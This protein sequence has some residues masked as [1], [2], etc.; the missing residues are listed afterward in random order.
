MVK[1]LG[2]IEVTMNHVLL[3]CLGTLVCALG[4]IRRP[5]N[6]Y[7]YLEPRF[8]VPGLIWLMSF[9]QV[10]YYWI[11][12]APSVKTIKYD[13]FVARHGNEALM[14]LILC[15]LGFWLGYILPLGSR[16]GRW[17]LP[18]N[19]GLYVRDGVWRVFGWSLAAFILLILILIMGPGI[20][21]SSWTAP[22]RIASFEHMLKI[23][24]FI[25]ISI[26]ACCIGLS[27]PLKVLDKPFSVLIG[28]AALFVI[29]IPLMSNFSRG[30]GLPVAFAAVAYAVRHRRFSVVG[31]GLAA[32]WV[33]VSGHA[34]LMGRG[35]HGH[36]A[37]LT[38][39]L[40]FLLSHSLFAGRELLSVLF[41][42]GDTWIVM[43]TVM[44]SVHEQ[45][46][47][48]ALS[49]LGW[50]VFQI[51]VPRI[52]GLHPE[53]TVEMTR[54]VGG[55]GSWGYTTSIFGD[56]FL[57]YSWFGVWCFIPLGVAYRMV[58]FVGFRISDY[59]AYAL[60]PF[61]VYVATSYFALMLGVFNNY[62]SWMVGFTYPLY[63]IVFGLFLLKAM[64]PRAAA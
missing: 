1:V 36:F 61:I 12:G 34:G 37:G 9:G 19:Y 21:S 40:G 16:I 64:Q 46:D 60:N 7:G 28:L 6:R 10:F 41:S 49:P 11:G 24:I 55:R 62:R 31:M 18:L 2:L 42:A 23:V 43:S 13:Q 56:A 17:F 35:V 22:G 59:H 3:A 14:F 8:V 4:F 5:A 58:S 33:L 50:V 53:W 27:W 48:G 45:T 39:Y 47:V 51:P 20:F 32:Y 44:T 25:L 57:H 63:L 26:S 52:F 54:F 38:L 30:S 15:V 29:S